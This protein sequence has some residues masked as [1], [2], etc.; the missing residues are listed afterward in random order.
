MSTVIEKTV[1]ETRFGFVPCSYDLYKK[2]KRLNFLYCQ[3]LR[4][5][6]AA[7]RYFRKEYQNRKIRKPVF[8][9]KGHKVS[10]KISPMPYPTLCEGGMSRDITLCYERARRPVASEKSVPKIPFSEE[11][12]DKMLKK[13]EEWYRI[14]YLYRYEQNQKASIKKT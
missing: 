5:E 2:I 11:Q 14:S 12:V 3:H 13:A 6:G 1:Y 10:Y 4:V 8:N 9:H 7:K